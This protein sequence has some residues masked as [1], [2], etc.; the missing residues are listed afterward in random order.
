LNFEKNKQDP[1]ALADDEYPAWLWTIL[2]RQEDKGDVGA[3]GDL[4]CESTTMSSN[5]LVL[6]RF[7]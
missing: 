6:A 7:R 2:Q 1:V 5:G 4:F 3:V